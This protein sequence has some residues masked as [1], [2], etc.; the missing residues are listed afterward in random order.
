TVANDVPFPQQPVVQLQDAAGNAVSQ[1]NIVVTAALATG[2]PVLGGTL[3]ATTN[4]SGAAVFATLKITGLVG[5]RTLSFGATGLAA[6]TASTAV[7]TPPSV[8]VRDVSGNAVAGVPVTFVV[9]GTSNGSL[10]GPNPSTSTG[11][12]ATVGSWTLST[13]AK[14]DTMTATSTGLAGS[15]VT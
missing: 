14:P 9:P 7:A 3:T 10:T 13:T 6:A 5:S 11:G 2:D 8:I 4:A 15:P 1:S 12:M